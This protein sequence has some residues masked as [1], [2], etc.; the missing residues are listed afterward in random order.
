MAYAE[1][2]KTEQWAV[3]R[4][5]ALERDGRMCV[6]CDAKQRL[7]VHHWRYPERVEDTTLEDLITL[8]RFCHRIEHGLSVLFPGAIVGRVLDAAMVRE[9]PLAVEELKL[10]LG[11]LCDSEW[12]ELFGKVRSYCRIV[13]K[14][15]DYEETKHV[16][17]E[18]W[19]GRR[20]QF[21]ALGDA[22]EELKRRYWKTYVRTNL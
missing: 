20:E 10:M 8:C 9:I 16:A 1:W 6:D 11:Y 3:L 2:L 18:I 17:A 21:F 7:Q 19:A 4:E 12:P 13:L 22:C 5:M 15:E 14:V